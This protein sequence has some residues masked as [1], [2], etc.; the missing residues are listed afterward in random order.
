MSDVVL[1]TGLHV[2]LSAELWV[3]PVLQVFSCILCGV[4]IVT[5]YT[6]EWTWPPDKHGL[7]RGWWWQQTEPTFFTDVAHLDAESRYTYVDKLTLF[8]IGDLCVFFSLLACVTTFWNAMWQI[9]TWF[10]IVFVK[11]TRTWKALVQTA[12]QVIKIKTWRHVVKLK[13]RIPSKC[14]TPSYVKL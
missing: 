12:V 13:S 11:Y 7:L 1:L 5:Q 14:T 2:I 4:G 9:Y 6:V 10:R 3:W 8:C